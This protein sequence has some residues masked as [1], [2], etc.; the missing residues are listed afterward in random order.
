[1]ENISILEMLEELEKLNLV[2]MAANE[3]GFCKYYKGLRQNTCCIVKSTEEFFK[4]KFNSLIICEDDNFI[5][6]NI[7]SAYELMKK[8]EFCLPYIL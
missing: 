1:M 6:E 2:G 7:K 4:D 5:I 3:N 8:Q